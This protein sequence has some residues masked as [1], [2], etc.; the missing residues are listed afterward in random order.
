MTGGWVVAMDDLTNADTGSGRLRALATAACAEHVEAAVD[1][2]ARR[3]PRA[4]VDLAT[5]SGECAA[6][7]LAMHSREL[8]SMLPLPTKP[9]ISLLAT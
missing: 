7:A 9:F 5:G 6:T 2:F 4:G 1:L 8:V 3:V